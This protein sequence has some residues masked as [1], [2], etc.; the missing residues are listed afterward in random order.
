[1]AQ[2]SNLGYPR[3]GKQRELKRVI[4]RYWSGKAGEDEVHAVAK[5]I[6][7]AAWAV[8]QQAGIDQIPCNDFTYYDHIL[9]TVCLWGMVPER[10]DHP[11]GEP[12]SLATYSA[13]ARGGNH[14][15]A[16][17]MT[18]WFDTNYHY[19]V[20]EFDGPAPRRAGNG[21]VDAYNEAKSQVGKATRPVIVGPLT[22]VLLG[23][24]HTKSIAEHVNELVPL[25]RD[26]LADLAAAGAEWVQIDEPCL[27]QD[28]TS[29]ELALYSSVY[30][31]LAGSASRPKIMLQTYFGSLGTNWDTVMSLPVDGIGLDLVRD[32]GNLSDLQRKGFPQDKALGAGV[33]NGRAV[34]K[35][36]LNKALGLLES[37]AE[38]VDKD[39]IIVGPS[40]SLLFLPHDVRLESSHD[41]SVLANLSFAE[42]RLDELV[43]LAKGLNE[44][45]DA[46]AA[47]LK[48]DAERL[49]NLEAS[50][51]TTTRERMASL[52]D[53]D[54]RRSA[55]FSE[56]IAAQQ[57]HIDLPPYPT[58][59]IG[60]FPQSPDVRSMRLK[61]RSGKITAEEYE[62]WVHGKMDELV[63]QQEAVGLDV[64]VHGEF[65]RSDMVEYFGEHLGGFITTEH[66][67]VQSYGSR[68]VR[69]P[70]IVG[71]VYRDHP[72]TV[73]EVVYAQSK[74]K[75]PMKGMLTGPVTILNWSFVRDDMPRSEVCNQ[76]AL[77]LRDEV[78]D[79]E[80][81]GIRIIQIDEPALR[82]GLPLRH[83]QWADYLDWAVKAFRLSAG[84]AAPGTQVHTHMCYSEFNDIIDSINA[85]DADVISIE[86][87][88][89]NEELLRAFT[90]NKYERMIGP[91]VYDVHSPAVPATDE[92]VARLTHAAG[93]LGSDILWVN[94]DC[95][96]KTRKDEEVWPS[97]EHMVAAAK[98]MRET[99]AA[100]K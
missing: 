37:I 10:F 73:N 40:A 54:F 95:G 99:V 66:G 15:A 36:D 64:L 13:M 52:S 33:L 49:A 67:W 70:V 97:L 91:G 26:L 71:D 80:A 23:K 75:K 68:C 35:A 61:V 84:G 50:V 86:N 43:I 11:A 53:A 55:P 78:A 92:I 47:E 57:Q 63:A 34:W 44:G 27:V 2:T 56:R 42:Q 22:F 51:N 4:E 38:T 60:S 93:V 82:E 88:R 16:L 24:H 62:A 28:R 76:I 72:M 12:V 5:E 8:Q 58:T 9:D 48:A 59:T 65:E 39:R 45:R 77:A 17:E 98:A 87:S 6:R 3:I 46:I 94:P 85:M 7:R 21:P 20:P 89:S 29:D 30:T 100:G 79:L 90:N 41:A 32:G 83:A 69:P 31:E 18:K 1:M 25:Y 14:V 81:A 74:T 19:L 96:L